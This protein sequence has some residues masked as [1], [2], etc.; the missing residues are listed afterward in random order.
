MLTKYRGKQISGFTTILGILYFIWMVMGGFPTGWL[1]D[2]TVGTG[3][4]QGQWPDESVAV[5]ESRE[6]IETYL[7]LI[8]I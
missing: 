4:E 8:H 1:Y 2:L 5:V 7:S 6:E 3:T